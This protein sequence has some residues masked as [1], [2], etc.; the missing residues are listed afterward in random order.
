MIFGLTPLGVVHT[1]ISLIA[2][3]A[4]ITAFFRF[5]RI[6]PASTAGKWYI[7]ATILTCLTALGIFQHGGFGKPHVLAIVTLVV[8][9]IAWI[10]GKTSLFGRASR[11]VETVLYTMTF[12][13]HMIPAVTET[14][15]RLPL[16]A[17][18]LPSAEA[19]QLQTASAVLFVLFL[20]GAAYQ[21]W[22]MRGEP[23]P[24]VPA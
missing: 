1:L 3:G 8:L 16:G 20:L 15:T 18:L 14:T 12:L 2:V 6:S 22:R 11:Y 7:I 19:P 21:V 5:G 9:G 17:P 4:G 13:F 24:S 10:A 23:G